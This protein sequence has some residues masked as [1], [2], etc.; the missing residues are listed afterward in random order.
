MKNITTPH[1]ILVDAS[2]YIQQMRQLKWDGGII[3]EYYYFWMWQYK[4][5]F[6]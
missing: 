1:L 2:H 4:S 3:I 5:S 6:E